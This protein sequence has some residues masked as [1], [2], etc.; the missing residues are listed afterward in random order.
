MH[1]LV[2]SEAKVHQEYTN[3]NLDDDIRIEHRTILEQRIDQD[4]ISQLNE[5]SYL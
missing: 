3:Q 1:Y 4:V 2:E 5:S